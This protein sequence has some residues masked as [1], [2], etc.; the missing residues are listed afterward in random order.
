[1]DRPHGVG[2]RQRQDV[3]VAGEIAGMGVERSA[4]IALRQPAR[5]DLGPHRAV[6]D[7]DPFAQQ[8][9]EFG[10]MIRLHGVRQGGAA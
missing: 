9:R 6:E 2:Q 3:V 7:Q 8:A 10:G 5:L 1:M 4:E